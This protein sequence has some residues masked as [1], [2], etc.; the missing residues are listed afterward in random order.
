MATN[1]KRVEAKLM[2]YAPILG[3]GLK[4]EKGQK[5]DFG[6]KTDEMQRKH[7]FWFVSRDEEDALGGFALGDVMIGIIRTDEYEEEY[8]GLHRDSL[9]VRK[10]VSDEKGNLTYE[11]IEDD[12]LTKSQREMK[13]KL[14][15]HM[16]FQEKR[17]KEAKE[18]ELGLI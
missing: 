6:Q 10:K 13:A 14:Q 7:L 16:A 15:K 2:K 3:N 18:K 9:T 4:D 8:L 12:E 17:I 5:Y 11:W 1:T